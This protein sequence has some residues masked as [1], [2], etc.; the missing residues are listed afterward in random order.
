MT[1]PPHFIPVLAAREIPNQPVVK[2]LEDPEVQI[3]AFLS[4]MIWHNKLGCWSPQELASV[5][6]TNIK[7]KTAQ[8]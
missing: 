5:L 8:L 7:T 2:V 3:I 1:F 4:L 6:Y